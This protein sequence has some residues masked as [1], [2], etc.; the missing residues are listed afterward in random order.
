MGNSNSSTNELNLGKYSTAKEVV[1]KCGT[2]T[3]TGNGN[4]TD[5]LKGTTAIVT[6]KFLSSSI[7]VYFIYIFIYILY[8]VITNVCV[9]T[10]YHVSYINLFNY[11]T[12]NG[13]NT[14]NNYYAMFTVFTI[15]Y[16]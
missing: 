4:G 7:C 11:I 3:G 13:Y 2:V 14:S 8:I 16:I 5:Y 10:I 9:F 6:G 1:D 15:L 12:V